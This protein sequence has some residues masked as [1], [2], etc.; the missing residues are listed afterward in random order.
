MSGKFAVLKKGF[1]RFTAELAR[2]RVR[3]EFLA[4]DDRFLD[5]VGVSRELLEQGLAA[6]PWKAGQQPARAVVVKPA[7]K[8]PLF[9]V[10]PNISV[11]TA[12]GFGFWRA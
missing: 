2:D 5:D 9:S 10:L 3:R 8:F 1:N 11:F 6:W 12:T 4:R 7:S